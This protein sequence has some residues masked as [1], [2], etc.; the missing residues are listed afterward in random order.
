MRVKQ[1][2]GELAV[3]SPSLMSASNVKF[4]CHYAEE[5]LKFCQD[6]ASIQVYK[7][8]QK[9]LTNKDF[10]LDVSNIFGV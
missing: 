2:S 8:N 10:I 1:Q 4:M 3:S 6:D 7:T 9:L 5:L